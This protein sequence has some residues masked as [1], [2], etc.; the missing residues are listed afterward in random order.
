MSSNIRVG[1]P[2]ASKWLALCNPEP[3]E[4]KVEYQNAPS[5]G[6]TLHI[7]IVRTAVITTLNGINPN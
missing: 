6:D 5:F 3:L 7:S 1:R 4:Q 2:N